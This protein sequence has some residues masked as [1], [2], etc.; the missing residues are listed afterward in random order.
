[1]K[2]LFKEEKYNEIISRCNAKKQLEAVDLYWLAKSYYKLKN[3]NKVI[4]IYKEY[5]KK[6][7]GK[8][9]LISICSWALYH[10]YLKNPEVSEKKFIDIT[11]YIL[12]NNNFEENKLLYTKVVFNVVDYYKNS[13]KTNSNEIIYGYL[14]ELE[15]KSL[16]IKRSEFTDSN[17]ITRKSKSDMEKWYSLMTKIC[18]DMKKYDECIRLS[19]EVLNIFHYRTSN[20]VTKLALNLNGY[21]DTDAESK[22]FVWYKFRIAK[23]LKALGRLDESKKKF[24]E[25]NLSNDYFFVKQELGEIYENEGEINK[26]ARYYYEGL[27][28][29]NGE[30]SK[31]NKLIE[32]VGDILKKQNKLE[33]AKL[34]YLL[35]EELRKKEQWSVNKNI[36]AKLQEL[37]NIN[38]NNSN[39][40]D[41]C[42]EIW[43][44]EYS[45]L[46][47]EEHGIIDKLINDKVGFIRYN[48]KSIFF[49]VNKIVSKRNSD[50]KNKNVV[51]NIVD[52]YD[53]KK[54]TVSKQAVNIRFI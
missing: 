27:L 12:K 40:L 37:D 41:Q 10:T 32:K 16:S 38:V 49:Q 4:D 8:D 30:L 36:K 53:K 24:E 54:K 1:M 31:K 47:P 34:N 25:I 18:L 2:K 51:F 42:F 39:I 50:L 23:S 13:K 45:N 6:N 35:I 3:Y 14:K 19:Q 17:G 28:C 46:L 9:Y 43:K 44:N 22:D 48:D 29:R 26:A 15:K 52:S 20:K 5:H 11:D 33:A 7:N 21:N